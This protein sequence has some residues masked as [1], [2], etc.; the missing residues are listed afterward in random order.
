MHE[1]WLARERVAQ[2]EFRAQREREEAAKRKKEEEEVNVKLLH[3]DKEPLDI[4]KYGHCKLMLLLNLNVKVYILLIPFSCSYHF[5][6][7]SK[8]NGK[9]SSGKREN[10]EI[11]SSRRGEKER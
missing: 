1:E 9:N 5:R 8:K 2:E 6:E 11:K 4:F 3:L 10:Q 7:E